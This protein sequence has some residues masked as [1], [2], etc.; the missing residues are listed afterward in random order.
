MQQEEKANADI[1]NKL[2]EKEKEF[3]QHKRTIKQMTREASDY[4]DEVRVASNQIHE[5]AGATLDPTAPM[6]VYDLKKNLLKIHDTV[7]QIQA[8]VKV[9]VMTWATGTLTICDR[10]SQ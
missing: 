1:T 5:L 2:L 6:T 8:M 7:N 9:L 4:I 3:I 10:H